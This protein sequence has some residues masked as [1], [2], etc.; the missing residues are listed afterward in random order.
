MKHKINV[1]HI[2]VLAPESLDALRINQSGI[3]VDATFGGGGHS[4]ALLERLDGHGRLFGFDQDVDSMR[5]IP[6][7]SRFVYV[8]SNFRYMYNFLRYH[9]VLGKVDG[10]LADLG[11]SSHHFDDPDRGFSYRFSGPL[12]MRMNR[13]GK[14]TAADVVRTYDEEA[15]AG[16]FLLYGELRQ[17]RQIAS[18]VVTARR[19]KDLGRVENLLE[20]LEPFVRHD[21][22]KKFLSQ[23]FMALRMEVN[24]EISALKEMLE[25]IPAALKQG[26]RFAIISY[27]S[28]EDRLV[29]N[30]IKS[31]NFEGDNPKDIYGNLPSP[32]RRINTKVITPPPEEIERNPRSRSAKLRVAERL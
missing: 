21:R 10:L 30:Y 16:I 22:E 3:Y 23:L 19:N 28:L 12:D 17:A 5:N 29:K 2:P 11:V 24:D 4:A 26:G 18:A 15:L 14:L 8:H 27:H 31:G 25:H 1:Y 20:V 7:D 6:D 32:F 9:N 13:M